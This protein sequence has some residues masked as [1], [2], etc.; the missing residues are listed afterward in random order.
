MRACGRLSYFPKNAKVDRCREGGTLTAA[1]KTADAD[2]HIARVVPGRS[3]ALGVLLMA[4]A[5]VRL[6]GHDMNISRHCTEGSI[7]AEG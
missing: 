1:A 4:R 2:M 5:E 6:P 7:S 3:D